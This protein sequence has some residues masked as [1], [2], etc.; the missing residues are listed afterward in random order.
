MAEE[1]VKKKREVSKKNMSFSGRQTHNQESN[2]LE[3][4]QK[5]TVDKLQSYA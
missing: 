5:S 4:M 1:K 2:V 3:A